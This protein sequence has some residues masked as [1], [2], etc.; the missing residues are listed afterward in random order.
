MRP[1]LRFEDIF[2]KRELR[3]LRELVMSYLE[4][5]YNIERQKA[6]RSYTR[7][8]NLA[9]FGRLD[10]MRSDERLEAISRRLDAVRAIPLVTP[11]MVAGLSPVDARSYRAS[12]LGANPAGLWR[13]QRRDQK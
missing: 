3:T 2:N 9:A 12:L 5:F 6:L 7:P 13:P 8:F 11:Q 10:W 1:I 4:S